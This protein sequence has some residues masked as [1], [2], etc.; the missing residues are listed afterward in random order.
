MHAIE[1]QTLQ[2]YA[3]DLCKNKAELQHVP[4]APTGFEHAFTA[5]HDK[6][7]ACADFEHDPAV[8]MEDSTPTPTLCKYP[9]MAY[10]LMYDSK[11]QFK[12]KKNTNG[13]K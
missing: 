4:S 5:F 1:Q 11:L 8:C 9:K 12:K 13:I 7:G 3:T 10:R 2:R 6:Q